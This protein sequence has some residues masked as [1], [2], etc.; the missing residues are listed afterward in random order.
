MAGITLDQAE[1][2]LSYWLAELEKAATEKYSI[3]TGGGARTVERSLE[4]AGKQVDYW[5][6]KV[7][8]LSAR[9]NNKMTV[10]GACP[11]P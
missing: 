10:I 2:K 9:S 6:K 5:D 8:K 3:Q 1:T 11:I 4:Q 7:Q